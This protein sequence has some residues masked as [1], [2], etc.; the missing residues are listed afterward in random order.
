MV[1]LKS[2][3]LSFGSFQHMCPIMHL[4]RRRS[5]QTPCPYLSDRIAFLDLWFVKQL[6]DED[7]KF[8]SIMNWF[9]SET[10]IKGVNGEY[11]IT[12]KT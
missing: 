1:M 4:L 11:P 9:F 2:K 12:G 7:K 3:L 6:C 8:D 5:L 10:Y